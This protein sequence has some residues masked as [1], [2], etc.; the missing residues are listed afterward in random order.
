MAADGVEVLVQPILVLLF[1]S[2]ACRIISVVIGS[3]VLPSP[4]HH[5][6]YVRTNLRASPRMQSW[7]VSMVE[8]SMMKLVFHASLGWQL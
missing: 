8:D 6:R 7:S 3:I 4:V 5:S 1:M 2:T